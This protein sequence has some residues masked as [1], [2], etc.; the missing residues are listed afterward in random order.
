MCGFFLFLKASRLNHQISSWASCPKKHQSLVLYSRGRPSISGFEPVAEDSPSSLGGTHALERRPSSSIPD[1][2]FVGL[3]KVSRSS[4][5]SRSCSSS[6]SAPP[7]PENGP[8]PDSSIPDVTFVGFDKVS[9]SSGKSR[10]CSSSWSA[11]PEPENGP[12][13]SIPDVTFVGFDKVSRSSG[14]SRS[15]SSSWSAPSEP[16]NGPEPDA[17]PD[18]AQSSAV[19]KKYSESAPL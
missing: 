18:N 7:E 4:G 14:K 11:P 3:E 6:W 17:N 9:R 13:S 19:C 8:E 12:D 1:V 10:S 16:E 5:K 15:C 2:T